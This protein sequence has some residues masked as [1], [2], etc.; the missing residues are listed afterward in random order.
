MSTIYSYSIIEYFAGNVPN[1]VQLEAEIRLANIS[2]ILVNTR[3]DDDVIH[4]KF[5]TSL[6]V[7]EINTLISLMINHVAVSTVFNRNVMEITDRDSPFKI[8]RSSIKCDSS[9]GNITVKMPK[10]SRNNNIA[11]AIKKT[12]SA[13][14]VNITTH[15]EDKIN[16][17]TTY[18][19]TSNYETIIVISDGDNWNITS[20]EIQLSNIETFTFTTITDE[21]GD[22]VVDNGITQEAL[23]VGTDGQVLIADSNSIIGVKYG[24][25]SDISGYDGNTSTLS[26]VKVIQPLGYSLTTTF[27]D[28]KFSSTNI[29]TDVNS[30]EHN[31]V[32]TERIDIKV[33]GIY[34]IS[35]SCMH[36]SRITWNQLFG[37]VM[38]NGSTI[39]EGSS[40][41]GPGYVSGTSR[42]TG[43]ISHSV[44]A[45]L[46]LGDYITVQYKVVTASLTLYPA[47]LSVTRIDGI[48]G[49]PG[50]NGANG[51][52][53][54]KGNWGTIDY[55]VN[56]AVSHDGTSYVCI[57]N[58]LNREP[59]NETY[60]D[61]LSSKGDRGDQGIQGIQG[62]T[63][64]IDW[65]N[66]W[67][68]DNYTVGQSVEYNGSSYI[69]KLN[70]ISEEV[71]TNTTYWN[72]L[73]AKGDNGTTGSG[74]T[75]IVKNNGVPVTGTP[76]TEID[77]IGNVFSVVDEGSGRVT[78]NN[79]NIFGSEYH[80]IEDNTIT[81]TTSAGYIQKLKMMTNVLPKG[82]Y[83]IQW[84]YQF[85]FSASSSSGFKGLVQLDDDITLHE[86]ETR[87]FTYNTT[88]EKRSV[89]GFTQLSLESGLHTIDI[90]FNRNNG[91]TS[92]IW[93]TRIALWRIS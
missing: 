38:L 68:S 15:N 37:H 34:E 51:D 55:N 66:T 1:I 62:L 57:V 42:I 83:Y 36:N 74:S 78:V 12:S 39:I 91:G 3:R 64:L 81:S 4:I 18:T 32:N 73:S 10:A 93:N 71:P 52:I 65:R 33:S 45:E 90:D 49:P 48:V 79:P 16:G 21:K 26:L 54:W 40:I 11:F 20:S 58:H 59:P 7:N 92:Y 43:G 31:K 41:E 29:E 9:N 5:D 61:I 2:P 72:L 88:N 50:P 85:R 14:I 77:F 53:T 47:M 22:L 44:K 30:I 25:I 56:D 82:E 27:A 84:C 70:T 76:H 75:I 23:S 63:G 87:A 6:S 86:Y 24:N 19:L 80:Y 35:F 17:L 60:W 89:S 8:T 69:C 28:M 46:S 13:N 67:V